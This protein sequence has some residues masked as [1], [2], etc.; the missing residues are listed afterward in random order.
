MGD[1]TL[2]PDGPFCEHIR[3]ALELAV[4]VQ[5]FKGAKQVIRRI[6]L[7]EPPVSAVVEQAV[8]CGESV[9]GSV[10][11]GLL[12]GNVGL[13]E[14]FQLVGDQLVDEAPQ[15]HHPLDPLLCVAAQLHWRHDRIF[16]V[17]NF[18]VHHRIGEILDVRVSGQDAGYAFV[19][20]GV[21]PLGG[22]V[23]ALNF[24]GGIF[25]LFGQVGPLD[26]INCHI[27]PGH[28]GCF[29]Q[30]ARPAPCPGDPQNTG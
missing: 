20:L 1:G 30:K 21:V 4:F 23:P 11:L 16:A 14:I 26:G 24:C 17:V 13:R 6:V 15:L 28:T 9:V 29:R 3:L 27:F 7:K 18:A 19:Q 22:N 25:E 10:Q 5:V 2:G 8:F 12:G